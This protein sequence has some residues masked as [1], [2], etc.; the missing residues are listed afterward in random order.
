MS[1]CRAYKEA[2]GL[3]GGW[4]LRYNEGLEHLQKEDLRQKL[5]E[6]G[7]ELWPVFWSEIKGQAITDK[8]PIELL[9]LIYDGDP[10]K[11]WSAE[12]I[13]G[14]YPGEYAEE[15]CAVSRELAW[16]L[17]GGIDVLG[18]EMSIDDRTYTV[19]GVYDSKEPQAILKGDI[20]TIWQAAEI[21]GEISREQL[22]EIML[23]APEPDMLV[24]GHGISSIIRFSLL[25]PLILGGCYA[26][27]C[28]YS[29]VASHISPILHKWAILS[30]LFIL[31]LLLPRA[32]FALPAWLLPGKWSDFGFWLELFERLKGYVTE[33][34]L[35]MP[36]TKDVHAR[37]LMLRQLGYMLSSLAVISVIFLMPP[38]DREIIEK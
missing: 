13:R 35:L 2:E 25:L 31:A 3:H 37:W 1:G 29:F 23:G 10:A 34:F 36:T 4:S 27:L 9:C 24:D 18:C 19:V 7:K 17:W 32:V 15:T 28:I 6:S 12:F 30:L 20:D 21:S 22:N 26:A 16:Q 38:R 8:N 33:Y 5:S 11:A 14:A